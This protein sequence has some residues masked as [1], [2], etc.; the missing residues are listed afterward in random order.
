MADVAPA[1]FNDEDLSFDVV[2]TTGATVR[3][4]DWYHDEYVDETLSTDPAHVRL[5][6]LNGGAPLLNTHAH[7]D[8]ANVI[9]SIVPGSVELGDA[10]GTARVRLADTEDVAIIAAKVKAGIFAISLW[11]MWCT[12][13]RKSSFRESGAPYWLSIGSHG[14]FPLYQ[15]PLTRVHR[16]AI[17][18]RTRRRCPAP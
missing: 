3:R 2:W 9:G 14:R 11:A 1:T 5:G 12:D 10:G 4:F 15:Y 18:A 7:Y 8:L 6:R 13:F 16:F 17:I